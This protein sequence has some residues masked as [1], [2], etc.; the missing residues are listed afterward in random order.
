MQYFQSRLLDISDQC[1]LLY[2]DW[3]RFCWLYLVV[4]SH[5]VIHPTIN[6]NIN[7][8]II[9]MQQKEIKPVDKALLRCLLQQYTGQISPGLE[10]PIMTLFD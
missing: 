9:P 6:K 7:A 10:Y 2:F 4:Y 8:P 3:T 5:H 1:L